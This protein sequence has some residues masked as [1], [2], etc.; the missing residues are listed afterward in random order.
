MMVQPTLAQKPSNWSLRE[1]PFLHEP[2]LKINR[3]T[4]FRSTPKLCEAGKDTTDVFEEQQLGCT[5][6][7]KIFASF[8]GWF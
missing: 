6:R 2:H 3:P 7:F 5:E 8:P 4:S 1:A